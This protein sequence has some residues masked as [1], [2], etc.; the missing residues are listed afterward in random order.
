[1]QIEAGIALKCPPRPFSPQIARTVL[2]TDLDRWAVRAATKTEF[3]IDGMACAYDAPPLLLYFR[4]SPGRH[5]TPYDL[6]Y[7]YQGGGLDDILL[8]TRRKRGSW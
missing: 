6:V 3:V 7:K 1:L 2:E 5:G 8:N 4:D